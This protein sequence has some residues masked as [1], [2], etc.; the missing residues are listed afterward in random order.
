[1]VR[2]SPLDGV[3]IRIPYDIEIVDYHEEKRE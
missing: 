1:M 2:Y 3:L